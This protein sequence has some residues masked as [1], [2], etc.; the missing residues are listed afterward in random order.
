MSVFMEAIRDA[1]LFTVFMF[2][3]P[4]LLWLLVYPFTHRKR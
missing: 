2:G 3:C 1:L 4:V